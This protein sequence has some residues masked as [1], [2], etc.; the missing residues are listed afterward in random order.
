MSQADFTQRDTIR[1]NFAADL[2]AGHGVEIGAGAF[3][4]ALPP[5]ATAAQYDLRDATE[6]RGLFGTETIPVRPIAELRSD[7]PAGADFLIA[8]NVLEHAPDPIGELIRWNA[9]VR[10]SGVVVLSLP[11]YLYCPD[12]RRRVAPPLHLLEDY[13]EATDGSDFVSCDTGAS[14]A[15]GWWEDFCRHHNTQSIAEFSRLALDNLAG[16]RPDFHWH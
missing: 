7:F 15:L 3:P 5:E 13:R 2:I 14:F 8:H 1:R 6:L 10:E 16:D 11:H 12:A 9:C 4:Q